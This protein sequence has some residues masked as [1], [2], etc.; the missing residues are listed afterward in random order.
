MN[1]VFYVHLSN[2][3]HENYHFRQLMYINEKEKL[4]YKQKN[5]IIYIALPKGT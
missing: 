5:S 4:D 1:N 2:Y 3:Y